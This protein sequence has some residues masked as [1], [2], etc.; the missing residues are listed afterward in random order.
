MGG[1]SSHHLSK[2][3][4]LEEIRRETGFTPSSIKR[5][6]HRFQALD[7]EGKGYLSKQNF[8]C[9]REL[10]LNPIG[11]RIISAFFGDGDAID[12]PTFIRI[13]AHFRPIEEDK[14]KE[15]CLDPEPINSRNNKLKFAFQL[16][17][18]DR[19]GKI[20]RPEL[21]EVLRMMVG[22]QVTNEQLESITDRTIQEADLDGDNAIS[23]QE[24]KQSLEKMSIEQK[25]SI[26]F[27]K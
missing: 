16:Y 8:L 18:Q 5:L 1:H 7:K 3:P 22:V 9:I 2:I 20:S 15:P 4:D 12:F 10:A 17:D 23:F 14:S 27:L 24:F 11:D 26:R 25:M 21:M 19:D 13:L 6:H